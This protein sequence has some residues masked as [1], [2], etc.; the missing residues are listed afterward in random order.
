MLD[1]KGWA[2]ASSLRLKWWM[3]RHST[4]MRTNRRKCV[5]ASVAENIETN[6]RW[7]GTRIPYVHS[8]V[9]YELQMRRIVLFLRV[10]ITLN[11]NLYSWDACAYKVS[12]KPFTNNF[13]F[14]FSFRAGREQWSRKRL[15]RRSAT[16]AVEKKTYMHISNRWIC[17]FFKLRLYSQDILKNGVWNHQSKAT[18]L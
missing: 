17:T 13:S 18:K 10:F 6:T 12:N 14:K 15:H 9:I 16:T 8:T 7:S 3:D 2:S 4:K 1:D 5:D 11:V